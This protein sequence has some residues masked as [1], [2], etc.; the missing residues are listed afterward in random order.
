[1]ERG[2]SLLQTI[3][4]TARRCPKLGRHPLTHSL[5]GSGL[6]DAVNPTVVAK[7][8]P[9][10]PKFWWESS[11]SHAKNTPVVLLIYPLLFEPSP[12]INDPFCFLVLQPILGNSGVL[13]RNTDSMRFPSSEARGKVGEAPGRREQSAPVPLDGALNSS[14]PQMWD[15]ELFLHHSRRQDRKAGSSAAEQAPF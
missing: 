1:M 3:F 7:L 6:Q 11:K 13:R 8:L 9:N 14:I 2:D 15:E 12:G 10:S 5:A 4:L